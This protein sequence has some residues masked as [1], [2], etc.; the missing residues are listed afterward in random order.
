MLYVG[1]CYGVCFLLLG[2]QVVAMLTNGAHLLGFSMQQT[3]GV[4][5]W[6]AYVSPD[7]GLWP[8]PGVH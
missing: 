1:A 6:E 7:D 4:Y 3:Y 8:I 5:P 2:S